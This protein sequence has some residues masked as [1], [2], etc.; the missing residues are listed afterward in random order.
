[1]DKSLLQFP[2]LRGREEDNPVPEYSGIRGGT[3]EGGLS[4]LRRI[5]LMVLMVN[6]YYLYNY[7]I[8]KVK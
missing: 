8:V 5:I 6:L 1:M 2:L 7:L 3:T 4:T